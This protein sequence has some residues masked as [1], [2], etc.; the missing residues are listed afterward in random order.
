M[1]AVIS[2]FGKYVAVLKTPGALRFSVAGFMGRAQMSMIGLGAVLLL[3]SERGSYAIAG[4]VSAIYALS[5]AVI[6]PQASRLVDIFGQ[7]RILRI[8]LALHVPLMSVLIALAMTDVPNWVLYVLAFFAG[9][10]QPN[11]GALVRAR[12]SAKLSGSGSLRT[13]FAWESMLDEVIFVAGPPL[14]TFLVIAVFPSAAM[15]V[16]TIVLAVGTWWF[17]SLRES[18]P[19]PVGRMPNQARQRPAIALP[20]VAA[21]A[22]IYVFVGGIFGS[23]EVTTVA[24]ADQHGHKGIAGLL[25]ALNSV[26]S[27][28]GGLV[29]GALTLRATLLRQFVAMLVL[30]SLVVLPL[31]ML[32]S[33]PLLSVGALIAG[34]AVA[35]VLISGIALVERIVPTA[36]LTESMSWSTAGLAVGLAVSSPI[37]GFI[38]D[39][40]PAS[41][42]YWVTAACAFAAAVTGMTQIGP[43]RRANRAA[44]LVVADG[45]VAPE[46]E[47][48]A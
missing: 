43:L 2:M 1:E 18:E 46:A 6:S 47:S 23:F 29:F 10:V 22:L 36:R 30:L 33:I 9:G 40:N 25:L 7:R 38:V 21:V 8:Q 27:L 19:K 37:A 34:V 5:M 3:Q 31:P 24:F 13:A 16:A 42:A 17:S 35:P 4:T 20:G 45:P 48:A 39:G 44:A 26:G 12:W 28:A 32:T 41:T 15:I 14:A 11:I